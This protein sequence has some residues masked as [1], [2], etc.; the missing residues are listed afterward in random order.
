M[1]GQTRLLDPRDIPLSLW[2]ESTK[3][4]LLPACLSEAYVQIID[5]K[6]L[7]NLASARTPG[8]GPVGGLTKEKCDEHFAQAFDGSAARALL[9]ILDPKSEIGSTSDTFIRCTAGN[10]ISLTDAPC[11]AGA[12]GLAFLS[13]VAELRAANVLPRVPLHVR[14][15]GAELS[16]HA[17]DY[18]KELLDCLLPS[19]EAQAIFVESDFRSWDVTCQLSNTD[20]VTQCVAASN[21]AAARLLVVANFNGFLELER[22]RSEAEPQLAELFRYASTE[23]SFAV[24]IEPRMN[25]AIAKG[26]F[27][28][29]LKA[30]L[31]SGWRKFARVRS[32][33][34]GAE[35]THTT[36]ARFHLPLAPEQ[37]AR[38]GLAV[39]P[40]TLERAA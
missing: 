11:G 26:G 38:V 16:S 21:G 36:E 24:W 28:D 23:E 18:A 35:P 4:L 20:L 12:A 17:R 10:V 25:R 19:L 6:G 7:R 15:I 33:P 2:N 40:I 1:S 37:T 9:A 34:G 27:F 22:K 32:H 30:R 14:L 13:A 29:W 39:M 31:E 5:R 8:D 3:T